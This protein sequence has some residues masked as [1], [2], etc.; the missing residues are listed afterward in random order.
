MANNGRPALD[1]DS[2]I[3]SE[4]GQCKGELDT[5]V[6]KLEVLFSDKN[7]NDLLS[8]DAELHTYVRR[9]EHDV[10]DAC[11]RLILKLKSPAL[12]YVARWS[13]IDYPF[14]SQDP[15]LAELLERWKIRRDLIAE[16]ERATWSGDVP[17]AKITNPSLE[18]KQ[19]GSASRSDITTILFL[20]ADPS[21][22][23]RLRL[24]QEFSDIKNSLDG[25][26]MREAFKLALPQFSLRPAELIKAV[27]EE[28]PRIIH[29][30]GHGTVEGKCC[31]K[32]TAGR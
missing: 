31:L 24:G 20:S 18:S 3:V 21:D 11:K 17:V 27:L 9:E 6:S 5:L 4:I 10:S 15:S 23:S 13:R 32:I 29:F 14:S 30:S 22:G 25:S 8:S 7:E 28:K 12:D 2:A 1:L 19:I 16:L 26:R